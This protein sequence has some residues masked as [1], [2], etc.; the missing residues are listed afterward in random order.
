MRSRQFFGLS[1][2]EFDTIDICCLKTFTF[3]GIIGIFVLLPV[4]CWG[5]QLQDIDIADFVNNSLDVFT[6]SNVNSGS[7]WLWVHFSAVYIVTVFI[8][9]LLF[10]E[11]IYISSRRIS[12]FYSSEPQRHHFTIL[13]RSIPTSSS[14][15]IGDSV[16]SFFSEL[17]PSTYLSHVVVH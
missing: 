11:Y 1:F 16:Q 6:I 2:S 13:V 10:Y 15:S 5:N 12:Y 4:N 9:I 7:H 8:C 14:G 17:Y 3:A